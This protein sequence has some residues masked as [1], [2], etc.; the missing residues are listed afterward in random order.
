MLE[1]VAIMF[2][3]PFLARSMGLL[4]SKA[5][6]NTNS[7]GRR[8]W[9]GILNRLAIYREEVLLNLAT[10]CFFL[11]IHSVAPY[12]SQYAVELGATEAMIALLGPFFAASAMSFR[13]VSGI[14]ADR[15]WTQSLLASGAAI[16]A[17]AQALYFI[18]TNMETLYVGRFVQ[19]VAVAIFIPASFQAAAIG[20]RERVISSLAWRNTVVGISFAVGPALGGYISQ[21]LG[22]R[23]LFAYSIALGAISAI[24]V[25]FIRDNRFAR[26]VEREEKQQSNGAWFL[27]GNFLAALTSLLLYSSSYMC[28]TLFLP[29]YHKQAG[30][31]VSI[32]AIYFTLMAGFNLLS[33][34]TFRYMLKILS[35]E[36]TAMLG[37]ALVSIGY[38]A[39]SLDPLSTSIIYYGIPA[40]IGAGLAIP[41]LQ[42]IAI[43]GIPQ[44]RRGLAS[45]I[46]TAMFDLGNLV[47]P[48]IASALTNT[49][50]DMISVGGYLTIASAAP[51]AMITAR[52]TLIGR[53]LRQ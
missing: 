39:I 51:I 42:V 52:G 41:S 36:G 34:L 30:L 10:L 43:T 12:I 45:A 44:G 33:R 24:F 15:G 5:I 29:A 17:I 23:A 18:S 32:I 28:L 40:G 9:E 1:H 48:V 49:Y 21:H 25:L 7:K 8:I 2:P 38:L 50:R 35:I 47:G 16:S 26:N 22:Y 53:S 4:S 20:N 13:L 3:L 31:G 11:T 19:G 37:I 14:L 46:Y 27:S 6:G